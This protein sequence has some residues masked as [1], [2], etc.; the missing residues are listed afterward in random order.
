MRIV[1]HEYGLAIVNAFQPRKTPLQ[2]HERWCP[3]TAEAGVSKPRR[4]DVPK[5]WSQVAQQKLET[6]QRQELSDQIVPIP[7]SL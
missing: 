7:A 3:P 2:Q 4:Q 5:S 6:R 1:Q